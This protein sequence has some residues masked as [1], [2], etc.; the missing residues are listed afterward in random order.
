MALKL[1]F[2]APNARIVFLVAFFLTLLAGGMG[3]FFFGRGLVLPSTNPSSPLASSGN[4][5]DFQSTFV[6]K[7]M[8]RALVRAGMVQDVMI[9]LSLTGTIVDVTRERLSLRG[10]PGTD[11]QVTMWFSQDAS[12]L[13]DSAKSADGLTTISVTDLR[14]GDVVFLY[15]RIE[16]DKLFADVVVRKDAESKITTPK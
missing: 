5:E 2:V 6:S 11:E 10:A 4:G 7:S 12:F 14:G 3:G 9:P 8:A 16:G 13:D 1:P 15:A